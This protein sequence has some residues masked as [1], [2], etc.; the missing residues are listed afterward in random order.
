MP[1]NSLAIGDVHL[2]VNL[3]D[4]ELFLSYE[5]PDVMKPYLNVFHLRV[6]DW[7]SDEVYCVVRVA[8][9]GR[10]WM[11]ESSFHREVG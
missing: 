8:I 10:C 9:D 6:I 1:T 7:I 2:D 4:F 3:P 11:V 5:L